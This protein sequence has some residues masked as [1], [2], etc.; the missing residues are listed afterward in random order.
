MLQSSPTNQLNRQH[1]STK[2][3]YRG[4]DRQL[5]IWQP[6]RESEIMFLLYLSLN[7]LAACLSTIYLSQ[8]QDSQMQDIVVPNILVAA[9]SGALT[10]CILNRIL[11]NLNIDRR[12]RYPM[13][14]LLAASQFTVLHSNSGL[15]EAISVL[16]GTLSVY[17]VLA[18]HRTSSLQP[19]VSLGFVL[20]LA[21]V[22]RYEALLNILPVLGTVWLLARSADNRPSGYVQGLLIVTLIPALFVFCSWVLLDCITTRDPLHFIRDGHYSALRIDVGVRDAA[23][24]LPGGGSLDIIWQL[25]SEKLILALLPLL[26]IGVALLAADY[27]L[28]RNE[29]SL[30]LAVLTLILPILQY[31]TSWGIRGVPSPRGFSLAVPLTIMI[32][33]QVISRIGMS[34]AGLKGWKI[35]G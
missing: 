10:S 24:P 19:L 30:T 32:A 9:A 27:L 6:S 15:V 23:G 3:P 1:I 35:D 17:L 12:W 14:L 25:L 20:G 2:E 11:A 26:A 34:R 8:M 13:P 22:T 33:G 29:L 7:L 5:S 4:L 28:S 31:L 21:S 18:W 16:L